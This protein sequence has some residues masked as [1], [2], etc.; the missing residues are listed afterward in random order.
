MSWQA[1]AAVGAVLGSPEVV[2]RLERGGQAQGELI[3]PVALLDETVWGGGLS[4][5]FLSFGFLW[6]TD[7]FFFAGVVGFAE[8]TF[9]HWSRVLFLCSIAGTRGRGS[10]C[11][12][13]LYHSWSGPVVEFFFVRFFVR[14]CEVFFVIGSSGADVAIQVVSP[15]NSSRIFSGYPSLIR[16]NLRGGFPPSIPVSVLLLRPSVSDAWANLGSALAVDGEVRWMDSCSF[17]VSF[18][19]AVGPKQEE[20]KKGGKSDG[21]CCVAG[22]RC[23]FLP[24]CCSCCGLPVSLHPVSRSKCFPR[25]SLQ[26]LRRTVPSS[27]SLVCTP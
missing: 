12:A 22:G 16:W 15:G 23:C 17:S 21:T 8:K 9:A 6:G 13:E 24:V 18:L 19:L 14:Q 4:P 25:D 5:F 1:H 3:G 26:P 7:F 20:K 10:C 11:G 2:L 27:L